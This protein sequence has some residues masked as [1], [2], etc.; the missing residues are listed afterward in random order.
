MVTP[1]HNFSLKLANRC[2]LSNFDRDSVMYCQ[3]VLSGELNSLI[4]RNYV[5]S[6]S[7][8]A[9]NFKLLNWQ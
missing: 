2:I 1:P 7:A 8:Q 3:R 6:E 4:L 5:T 9:H